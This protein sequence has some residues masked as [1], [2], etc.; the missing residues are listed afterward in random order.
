MRTKVLVGIA[1]LAAGAFTAV[2]QN[3]VYSL[4]VVGYINLPLVEGFNMVANQL[5]SDGTGTNNTIAGVFG[6]NLPATLTASSTVYTWDSVAVSYNVATYG[7]VKGVIKWSGASTAAFNPGQGAWVRVGAGLGAATVTT[8]GQV[9]QG[10]LK[11]PNLPAAGGFT[12]VGSQIPLAGGLTAT[13]GY[14]PQQIVGSSEKVYQWDPVGASFNVNTYGQVKGVWKWAPAEPT[15][16]VGEGF[17]LNAL[18]GAT[19][20]TNFT[21]Q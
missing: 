17:W 15:I 7:S 6:T 11:N 1:A 18:A 13:L 8:V 19:W 21:V 3:N 12:L 9:M 14:Q 20:T 5:D 10:S 2:A 16:G 4:N